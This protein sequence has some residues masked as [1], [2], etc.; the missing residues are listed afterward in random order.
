MA[1]ALFTQTISKTKEIK[2]KTFELMNPNDNITVNNGRI[3]GINSKYSL[4][5]IRI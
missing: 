1:V 3:I 2:V 5:G 4:I